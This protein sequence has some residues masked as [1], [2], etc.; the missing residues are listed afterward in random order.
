MGL[1][2]W[3][4]GRPGGD[5]QRLV[6]MADT[7]D[8]LD[9]ALLAA[10]RQLTPHAEDISTWWRGQA[11]TAYTTAW[12]DYS[13]GLAPIHR[14]IQ[15]VSGTLHVASFAI[16]SAQN[17]YDEIVEEVVAGAVVLTAAAFLTFGLS[18]VG[19]AGI[20]SGA[21]ATVTDLLATLADA[22][23]DVAAA[24]AEALAA[25]ARI[26]AQ[27]LLPFVGGAGPGGGMAFALAGGGSMTVTAT[28]GGTE[29]LAGTA[30]V[31]V[32]AT[33]IDALLAKALGGGGTSSG[34]MTGPQVGPSQGASPYPA[35]APREIDGYTQHGLKQVTGRD[36]GVGVTDSAMNDA[37]EDPV[38]VE[39]QPGGTFKYYGKSAV[40]ILNDQG[41]VVTAW[42]KTSAAWRVAP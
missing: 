16:W 39:V 36:G 2:G 21:V 29:L 23:A 28:A 4:P 14:Q 3:M 8:A 18:E 24:I 11:A 33:A 20:V 30:V 7:W 9:L 26:A 42:A 12:Y 13:A 31:A 40:V 10:E 34:S 22:L 41:E 35:G 19:E 6:Q 17:R 38:K 25:M 37:V 15:A 27:L 5:P 1:P 32:G